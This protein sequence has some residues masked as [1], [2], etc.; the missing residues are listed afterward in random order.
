MRY[1]ECPEMNTSEKIELRKGDI[2]VFTGISARLVS[3]GKLLEKGKVTSEEGKCIEI[4]RCEDEHGSL[5]FII[6]NITDKTTTTLYQHQA[7]QLMR[8]IK[9]RSA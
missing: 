9:R 5:Y 3:S 6:N 1:I 2:A 4:L 7:F 8:L